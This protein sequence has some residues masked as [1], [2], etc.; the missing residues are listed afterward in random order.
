ML[1]DTAAPAIATDAVFKNP[2]REL[3]PIIA[4]SN[5]SF[6]KWLPKF[7]ETLSSAFKPVK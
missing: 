3:L 2:L 7:I 1:L 4:L 6:V 5:S